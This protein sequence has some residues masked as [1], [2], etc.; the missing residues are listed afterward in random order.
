[1]RRKIMLILL[2]AFAT[3]GLSVYRWEMR[4]GCFSYTNYTRISV[5]M[6]HEEV[7]AMLGS[8]GERIEVEY[9]PW[10]NGQLKDAPPNWNKV[11]WGDNYRQWEKQ[12]GKYILIGFKDEK[13]LSKYYSEPSL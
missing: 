3:I 6:S 4:K 2:V 5:G 13:V 9:L 12:F 7:E 11:V 1:M 8:A 10:I